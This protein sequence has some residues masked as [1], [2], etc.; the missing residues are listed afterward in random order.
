MNKTKKSIFNAVSMLLN[1]VIISVLGLISTNIIINNYGS[2]VNGVVAT[3]NQIVN[4]LLI[5]EGG[6]TLAVNVALYKPFVSN[7][8]SLINK[9]LSVAKKNFVKIGLFFLVIGMLI[10][11]IYPLFIKSEL[12]YLTVFLIFFMVIISTSY[13]LIFTIRHQIMFQVSQKEYVYTFVSIV[14]NICTHLTTIIM[15]YLRVDII[16]IR[17]FVLL[18]SILNGLIIFIIFRRMF[19]FVK[20]KHS[21]KNDGLIVG[22]KDLFIQK[23][24]SIIYSSFPLL[25]ISTFVSTT[26]SS[27]YVVYNSVYNIIR[28]GVNSVISSP[29][30][31]FGQLISDNKIKKAFEKFELYEYIVIL[32]TS[33]LISVTLCLIIPFVRLYT[34]NIND[35]NYVNSTIAIMLA[36]IVFLELIHIP[37]GHIINV[38]GNFRI[39]KEINVIVSSILFVLLIVLGFL[40]NLYGILFATIITNIILA[41]LE[42]RFVHLNVFNSNLKKP[43]LIILLN[44]V[45]IIILS[46]FVDNLNII[47]NNY[48]D[49]IK[50]G[51]LVFIFNFIIIIVVNYIFF[52]KIIKE[53][54]KLIKSVILKKIIRE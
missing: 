52:G 11:L 53:I 27:V 50:Y 21:V 19:S 30:N 1:T 2:D 36:L 10:S 17:L 38:S 45:L 41:F 39:S 51:F 13:N 33:I 20:L 16:F 8:H 31:A 32:L 15:A 18:Y 3:A 25:F 7:N 44:L 48:F 46:L 47:F 40:F 24:T 34:I 14:I 26:V 9:I 42:M 4:L 12:D 5:L 43:I 54:I 22:T 29:I 49:F 37:S 23:I 6:F 28:N 35:V